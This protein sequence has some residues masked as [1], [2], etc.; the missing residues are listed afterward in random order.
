MEAHRKK[1]NV[2]CL[3]GVVAVAA[4]VVT[5]PA[6]TVATAS[7]VR[8]QVAVSAHGITVDPVVRIVDGI[9]QGSLNASTTSGAPLSYKSIGSSAGGK[10]TLGTVTGGSDAET[11]QSFTVLPYASWLD[12]TAAKGT[13]TFDVRVTS[14]K[15]SV[16]ARVVVDTGALAPG[17]TPVAFTYKVTSFDGTMIS[18]NFF[19]ASGLSRGATAFTVLDAPSI[20]NP[21]DTSPLAQRGLSVGVPG[22]GLLRDTWMGYEP[23]LNVVTWDLRGTGASGGIMQFGNPFYDGRDVSAIVDWVVSQTPAT[24][25]G[26][27]DP[28]IGMVGGVRSGALQLTAA[29]TDPRIDAVV[30]MGSWNSLETALHPNGV[31]RAGTAARM[32]NGIRAVGARTNTMITTAFRRGARVGTISGAA[33]ELLASTGPS[34]LLQQMQAPS[35]ILQ[36]SSDPVARLSE[37]MDIVKTILANPYGTPVKMAWF[38]GSTKEQVANGLLLTYTRSWLSKYVAGMSLPDSFTPTFLWWDQDGSR[39]TSDHFPFSDGFNTSTPVTVT[40]AGGRLGIAPASK[41]ALDVARFD[42]PVTLPAGSSVVGA[43]TIQ[44][45]YRGKGDAP[46]VYAKI[47]DLATGKALGPITTP[48]P[49]VLDGKL[50]TVSVPLAV[51]VRRASSSGS[52]LA[53]RVMGAS[54]SFG[55]RWT[56]SIRITNLSVALPVVSP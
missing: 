33:R 26:A 41:G 55:T 50:H 22:I 4:T 40:A 43:P 3:L 47:V 35:L 42:V 30:P 17:N 37:S 52:R 14:G 49:V 56:G 29:A 16:T 51:V 2:R 24:L 34:I 18:T 36:D 32:L 53:L 48:V 46:A 27:T 19:P 23:G 28:A 6:T 39:S 25:N 12:G 7:G 1:S 15:R 8:S 45:S 5:L 54:K 9:I 31:Y 20:G 10:L 11:A 44:F 21:G 13:E 38:D